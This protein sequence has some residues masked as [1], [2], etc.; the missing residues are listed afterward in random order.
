MVSKLGIII[1]EDAYCIIDDD[2]RESRE[3]RAKWIDD[4]FYELITQEMIK[5]GFFK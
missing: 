4:R 5:D 3:I 2:Y 1:S